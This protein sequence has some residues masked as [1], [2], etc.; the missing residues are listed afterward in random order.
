MPPAIEASR[1]TQLLI[2]ALVGLAAALNYSPL[3]VVFAVMVD[4]DGS[5]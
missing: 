5:K 3:M 1:L 4:G 2:A